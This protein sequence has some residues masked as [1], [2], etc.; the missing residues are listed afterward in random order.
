MRRIELKVVEDINAV[1][2]DS[3][4]T[5]LQYTKAEMNAMLDDLLSS[6]RSGRTRDDV[7]AELVGRTLGAAQKKWRLTEGAPTSEEVQEIVRVVG[8]S[9]K[10]GWFG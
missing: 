8:K 10:K 1:F 5:G 9:I 4:N 3:Q 7:L 6:S 2:I